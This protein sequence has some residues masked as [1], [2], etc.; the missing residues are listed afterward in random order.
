[1]T[2][3]NRPSSST[4]YEKL[5]FLIFA[6][7][8]SRSAIG[9]SL[10]PLTSLQS[11]RFVASKWR[12]ET[13][14]A[15]SASTSTKSGKS[16]TQGEEEEYDV[17]VI[18]SGIGGLSCASLL[19]TAGRKVLV[20]ESHYEIGGCAHEYAV[21]M[22]GQTITSESLSAD[23][24]NVFRFEAGPSLYAGLSPDKS[25]NPL[26]HIYQMIEEVS[27]NQHHCEGNEIE[28]FEA[29]DN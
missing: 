23:E 10:R 21:N 16:T 11:T 22:K 2:S 6:S 20:V 8:C 12:G 27:D 26:K 7:C 1:M 25:P 29:A 18:G 13:A 28:A 24:K 15:S 17:V 19:A 14:I 4:L 9:F 5:F 3:Y